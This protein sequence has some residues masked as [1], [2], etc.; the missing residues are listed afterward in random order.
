MTYF[1]LYKLTW[2]I[3]VRCSLSNVFVFCINFG[4]NSS[5]NPYVQRLRNKAMTMTPPFFVSSQGSQGGGRL[6]SSSVM[7]VG[8]FCLVVVS[9]YGVAFLISGENNDRLGNEKHELVKDGG[10]GVRR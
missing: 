4:L 9:G 2:I 10:E 3:L 5:P 1:L 8:S 7:G 6:W